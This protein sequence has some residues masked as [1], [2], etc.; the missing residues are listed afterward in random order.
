[1]NAS[2]AAAATAGPPHSDAETIGLV[3]MAHGTS[4]FFHLLLPPLFPMLASQYGFSYAEL[5]LLVTVFF[6]ISGIG[7]ALAGFVVDRIG[8]YPVLLAA[9]VA[10]SLAAL[11]ASMADSYAGFMLAAAL[12]GVGNAP[13][14]PADF[15][16]LNQRV[17][18]ARL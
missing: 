10:F 3:G 14:H 4:H 16:I 9:M 11:A 12:A 15:T 17:S 5:G 18:T 7:Q 13:F 8:A 1:M 2:S 6:I